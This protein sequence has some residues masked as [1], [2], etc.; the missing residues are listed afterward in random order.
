VASC[1]EAHLCRDARDDPFFVPGLEGARSSMTVPL[2][3][4]DRVVAC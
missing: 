4:H 2:L 1:G 3:L